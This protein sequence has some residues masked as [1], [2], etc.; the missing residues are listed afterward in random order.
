MLFAV[1]YSVLFYV[2]KS[3]AHALRMLA[4]DFFVSIRNKV[5]RGKRKLRDLLSD[6][7]LFAVKSS[8]YFYVRK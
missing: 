5:I 2:R 4:H 7:M 8:D 1:K 3:K 6:K